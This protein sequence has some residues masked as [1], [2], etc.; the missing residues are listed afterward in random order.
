MAMFARLTLAAIFPFAYLS[1]DACGSANAEAKD[2]VEIELAVGSDREK[3]A[4]RQLRQLLDAYDLDHLIETRRVRIEGGAVPHSHPVLTLN[5]RHLDDDDRQLATF[6]HEQLHWRLSATIDAADAAI[7]DLRT[8]YPDVPVGGGQGGRD[9]YSTYLHLIIGILEIDALADL[10]GRS[11]ARALIGRFDIYRWVYGEV[12]DNET[13]IR[14]VVEAHG[15]A[16]S[17]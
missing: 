1:D 15:L 7:A 10:L 12:L 11:R 8:L 9:A 5:T 3:A 14:E 17:K 2:V 6:V 4:E 13:Q 16:L